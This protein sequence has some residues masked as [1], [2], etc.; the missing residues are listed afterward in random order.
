MFYVIAQAAPLGL[1]LVPERA[2][3][4]TRIGE[5]IKAAAREQLP[6]RRAGG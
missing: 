3:E 2:G 4:I 1:N 5:M 6:R